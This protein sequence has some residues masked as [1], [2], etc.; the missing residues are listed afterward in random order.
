MLDLNDFDLEISTVVN[1]F[2]WVGI[3]LI[4]YVFIYAIYFYNKK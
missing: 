3:I 1:I 4:C 2:K